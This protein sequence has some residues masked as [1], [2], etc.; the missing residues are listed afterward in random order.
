MLKLFLMKK[1]ISI[2]TFLF[3]LAISF[4][5]CQ[6]EAS[7]IV[8]ANP[9]NLS[10]TSE[11]T[12]LLERVTLEE[13]I[14]DNSI[15]STACF[16]LKLPVNLTV[17]GIAVTI[18]S[19][20]DYSLVTSI[21]NTTHP[22]HDE[23]I[24]SFPI[25]VIAIN[26]T[27]TILHNQFEFDTLKATCSL[28]NPSEST[29]DCFSFTFPITINT[30]NPSFQLANNYTFTN[31]SDFLAMLFN[32]K[33]E[34]FYAINYPI[35]INYTSAGAVQSKIINNNKEL[36]DQ[37]QQAIA[38]C[39]HPN[40]CSNPKILVEDLI[41]Y[42]PFANETRNLIDNLNASSN[43]TPI[44]GIDRNGEANSAVYFPNA[45]YYQHL[46][47]NGNEDNSITEEDNF[48]VSVWFK[49]DENNSSLTKQFFSKAD[50][51]TQTE[52]TI[53]AGNHNV[54]FIGKYTFN[55]YDT[56][57]V[58]NA[59]LWTDYS[60]WHHLVITVDHDN[61]TVKLYRDGVLQNTRVNSELEVGESI[62]DY[63]IG[64]NF[65]GYL[66]DLRVYKKTLKPEQVTILYNLAG[67]SNTCL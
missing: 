52:F 45:S 54:P 4:I 59:N 46:K 60:N 32:L 50:D 62:T 28:P 31:N 9:E 35:N 65:K 44:Y 38:N 22:A 37:I 39:T 12:A 63:F 25:T 40:E 20:N 27:E 10:K 49:L 42:M 43:F 21:F 66:D 11:L 6:S 57:W 3:F 26:G 33:N 67:D 29:V 64:D 1:I 17:N 16:K 13:Q 34:E 47:L 61:N 14:N 41:I 58:N 24:F 2:V 51:P 5:G 18:A 8:I 7:S 48:S 15:D 53:G 30:Y 23:I 36:S 56:N 55:L 19:T